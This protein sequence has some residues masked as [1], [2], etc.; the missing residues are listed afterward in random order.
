MPSSCA[1]SH[2]P[3]KSPPLPPQLGA[4]HCS[5]ARR[6]PTRAVQKSRDAASQLR[7]PD[8][9][10]GAGLLLNGQIILVL[11]R[12]QRSSG[13][14]RAWYTHGT[15]LSRAG[16][17]EAQVRERCSRLAREGAQRDCPQGKAGVSTHWGARRSDTAVPCQCHLPRALLQVDILEAQ[18]IQDFLLG[19]VRESTWAGREG[20][21]GVSGGEDSAGRRAIPRG[22]CG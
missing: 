10:A 2:C 9:M 12:L 22:N 4:Q 19:G 15:A 11:G 20:E 8:T 21:E 18:D 6:D 1:V 5:P 14:R 3:C 7:P 13:Q 17:L 16:A